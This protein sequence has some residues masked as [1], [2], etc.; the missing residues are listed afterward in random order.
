MH[1][2]VKLFKSVALG[3]MLFAL[4]QNTMAQVFDDFEDGDFTANPEWT[5]DGDLFTVE[6]GQL[7]SNSPS[8][9]TYYLNT[10]NEIMDEVQWEFF[11]DLQLSTSG[12]NYVDVYLVA[13]DDLATVQNGYFLRFGGTDDEIS[14][15]KLSSG[16]VE[17]LID[18][19]DDVI[20]GS[21]NSFDVRVTRSNS[22]EWNILYDEDQ[23]G[24]FLSGGSVVDNEISETSFFGILIEQSSAASAVNS[25]FFDN[26]SVDF[27]PVDETPPILTGGEVVDAAAL[28]LSFSEPLDPGTAQNIGNY[29][30]S[31]VAAEVIGASL[32]PETGS[33]VDLVL[34][35]PLPNPATFTIEASGVEDLVGNVMTPQQI[36]L[37]YVLPDAGTFKDLVINEIFADPTPTQGLPE[38]EYLELFNASDSFL[39]LEGWTL[40]NTTSENPLSQ[41]LVEPGAFVILC[42][43]D[44]AVLFES[45]GT[46][47]GIPSFTALSNTGDSLTLLNATGEVIDM[48]V[49]SDDWYGNDEQQNGGYSLEL[50]NPFTPCSGPNNWSASTAGIGGTPGVENAILDLT[51]DTE[52]PDLVSF[53]VISNTEL[54][55]FFDEAL[56][57]ESVQTSGF[58]WTENITTAGFTTSED[59]LSLNLFVAPAF[60][61][62]IE[63]ELTINGIT[64]CEGN[65]IDPSSSLT[66]I[67]GNPAQ[68]FDILIT[69]IMAD[70]SPALN[71]LPEV[72]YF[73][74]YNASDVAID[75]GTIRLN[76]EIFSNAPVLM[77]GEYIICVDHDAIGAFDP[78]INAYGI[79]G[80]GETY[81]TNGGRLLELISNSGEIVDRVDYDLTWYRDGDKEDGGYSLE[82]INLNEPCRGASNWRGSESSLG[83]TPGTVNS[84][85]STDPDTE[86]PLLID[87]FLRS[88]DTLELRFNERLD[89]LSVMMAQ[90]EFT[91][92]LVATE[93]LNAPPAYEHILVVFEEPV[94]VN[95]VY[96]VAITGLIDC[97]GNGSEEVYTGRF[98]LPEEAEIGDLLINEILFNP[99]TGGVDFVE[100]FNASSKIISLQNRALQNQDFTTRIIT[101]DPKVLFP[102]SF[103]VLTSDALN[104]QQEYPSSVREAFL[105]M[106]S[107]PSYNNG[108]GTVILTDEFGNPVDLFEYQED[109]HLS[110][111]NSVKGVSL[112]RLS[113]TRPTNDPGNW[114]SAAENVGFATPGYQNS[115]FNPEGRARSQFELESEVFSP[116][117]DG[118]QDVLLLNYLLD[119]P[120]NFVTVLVYDRRGREVF[121]IANNVLLGTEGTLSWDGVVSNGTKARIGPHVLFISLF[122][123]DG[124]TETFKIPFVVAGRLSN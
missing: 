32:N 84:V 30:L 122:N 88:A 37:F 64:D 103:L 6:A 45:F 3:L 106:E 77:P 121:E 10:P 43:D 95:V 81:L 80:L 51:P 104:I 70:P 46:V 14:F 105:E 86:P 12:A 99:P 109:Y 69:E 52:G 61:P 39:D 110:L 71:E 111:L 7:R 87:A 115:Q 33:T 113:Y 72:E 97:S 112:E 29:Q 21:S 16:S 23:T 82:R 94:A 49:Y 62:G 1:A 68:V 124:N 8:A 114:T 4:S 48:V 93:V 17:V 90:I 102:G 74:L 36:E 15:F 76:D 123:Q 27:I 38:A 34:D 89:S 56:D 26:I 98:G 20:S 100:I 2:I 9:N 53:E 83:G 75:L 117:N 65:L 108:D 31:G 79:Q 85:N 67:L 24:V 55:L 60:Q 28:T 57:A 42:D 118:F 63:Y 13:D 50:I 58:L 101:E 11:I 22:G 25:H 91:N 107:L 18:G 59:L 120:G 44:D 54:V 96:E 78:S 35:P 47:I 92:D 41:L 19:E 73:E 66:I 119:T 40:V 116:D 5:G